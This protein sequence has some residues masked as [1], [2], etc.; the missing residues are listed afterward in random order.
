MTEKI[1]RLGEEEI[2]K[3]CWRVNNR[4]EVVTMLQTEKGG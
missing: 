3:E 2:R 1:G 4:E